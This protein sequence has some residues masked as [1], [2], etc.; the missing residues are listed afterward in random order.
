MAASVTPAVDA[1]VEA[2][3]DGASATPW[4]SARVAWYALLLLTL[5]TMLGFFDRT[6]FNL[7]IEDIR[8]DFGLTEIQLGLLL[9]PAG[10]LFYVFIGIPLARLVDIY[11]RNIVIGAGLCVTSGFT[12]L[13]GLAQNY[14]Q[15]FA[16]RTFVGVGGSAHAPGA[17]SMLA[18][19]FPPQRLPRAIAALQAGFIFGTGGALVIGGML[20][21]SVAEWT[22]SNIGP[23]TLRGWQWLLIWIGIPGIM[24]A[25]F[26]FALRDP[27]RRGK[28]S[29]GRSLPPRQVAKEIHA[30]RRIYYPLFVGLTLG[31]LE[32]Q[33]LQEWRAPW[34]MRTYGWTADEVGVWSGLTLFAAMPLGLLFGTWL[35]ERMARKHK[36][37]PLRTTTLVFGISVP[38]IIASFLMPTGELAVLMGALATF[39]QIGAA[40]LYNS[41]IQTITPNELRGQ[42][43]AI[44][45]FIMTVF[46]AL[47]SFLV[48]L[49]TTF[50]V[51]DPQK[52]WISLFVVA[53]ALLPFALLALTRSL[54]P[55]AEEVERLEAKGLL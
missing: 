49:V 43:T 44:Y 27:P 34:L 9:G 35:A 24:L 48:S 37:A 7:M 36:D 40:A 46:G 10:I 26:I 50:V 23:L 31:T 41:A 29:E 55:Y 2:P 21:S 42:V 4:P 30:R 3:R 47:G 12:S 18:D 20:V 13:G 52:L 33:G 25:P 16:S 6:V 22:P 11:P 19:Y 8:R 28:M 15:F 38:L 53:A 32:G 45:I 5:A 14:G 39:F 51:G 54:Q 17:Y 1:N